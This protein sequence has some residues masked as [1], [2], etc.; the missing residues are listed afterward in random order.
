MSSVLVSAPGKV[1]LFGEHAVVYGKPAIA[2]SLGLRTYAIFIT[3]SSEYVRLWLP[4]LFPEPIVWTCEELQRVRLPDEKRPSIKCSCY[5]EPETCL[6]DRYLHLCAGAANETAAQ[7]AILAFLHLYYSLCHHESGIDVCVRSTIPVGAGLGSSAAYSACLAAGFLYPNEHID[8]RATTPT[9]TEVAL[10]NKWAFAAEQIIHGNPSGVD[11]TVAT[12]GI[13]HHVKQSDI[14]SNNR[15]LGGALKYT[16]GNISPLRG[17]ASLR[18]LLVDTRVPKNT[19]HQVEKFRNCMDEVLGPGI[20]LRSVQFPS[21]TLPM[22]ESIG[23]ISSQ[24]EDIF[25]ALAA[26]QISRADVL[27]R[28]AVKPKFPVLLNTL[29]L[30]LR[31]QDMMASN[32]SILTECGMSHPALDSVKDDALTLGLSSKMTGAGGGGC[33]LILLKDET[34]DDEIRRLQGMLDARGFHSFETTVGCPGVRMTS[35]SQIDDLSE[36]WK[37]FVDTKPFDSTF[38]RS[39][40]RN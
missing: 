2:A 18:L 19:K 12:Y 26:G 9:E 20:T 25:D 6:R 4:D 38:V 28:L 40:I 3:N 8:K 1:I 27:S 32:H 11:N 5:T 31:V 24:C 10:I 37:Q 30:M 23:A 13:P 39:L 36:V 16:K 22:V 33:A 17:F 29:L 21:T 15:F 35:C 14:C 34:T 7:A